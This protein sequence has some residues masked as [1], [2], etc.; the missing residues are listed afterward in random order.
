M[1]NTITSP[2]AVPMAMLSTGPIGPLMASRTVGKASSLILD[3]RP[4]FGF[5]ATKPSFIATKVPSFV[6][7]LLTI[8]RW[9]M[10][11]KVCR[12]Y[13]MVR[14]TP[15]VKVKVNF[16]TCRR[17]CFPSSTCDNRICKPEHGPFVPRI[18]CCP[19]CRWHRRWKANGLPL[20][21]LQS[22]RSHEHHRAVRPPWFSLLTSFLLR[23]N[24]FGACGPSP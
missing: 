5:H 19:T 17:I 6:V 8:V 2:S 9:F 4:S 16:N 24:L 11:F 22:C 21:C 18:R 3:G 23:P 20:I 15:K 12:G 1:V 13:W 14:P 7:Q 10:P